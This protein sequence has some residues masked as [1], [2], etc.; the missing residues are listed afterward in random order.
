MNLGFSH[1]EHPLARAGRDDLRRAAARF[2]I[3]RF[4]DSPRR[5]HCFFEWIYFANVAST[6]DDRSVYLARKALGEELA[7]LEDVPIDEDTIVV[8]VPD[9]SKCAA[10]AMAYRARR[11][12]RRRADSQSLHG[13]HVH[14]RQRQP[15]W[16]RPQSK[17]TPLREV[18]EGKRVLLVEDSIVRS[19]TMRVLISRIREVGQGP[20]D[21]RPRGLPA[22]HRALLLRHRHVDDRRAVR[23]AV[24]AAKTGRSKKSTRRWPASSAPIRSATCRSNR[25]PGPSAG[26]PSELCRACITGEYPTPHGQ[27]LYQ[28]ALANVESGTRDALQRLP[29]AADLRNATA[30]ISKLELSCAW[31]PHE[32]RI[33]PRRPTF[34]RSFWVWCRVAALSFGGPAGQIA[35]MH[36]ILVEEKRWVSENRFLHALNYCM[37]LPGPEAQQLATYI[38]WLLH[39]TA[40][41]LM[42]GLLFVLPG[43]V[44]ILLLSILYANV[45]RSDGRRRHFLRPEAGRGR[46]R[47]RSGRC[48]SASGRSR[49]A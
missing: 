1:R 37:L 22:D 14:R 5:A 2:S 12:Q 33:A 13:P 8:P 20:R 18:L 39:R 30:R 28:I 10:D 44:S 15:R 21:S 36:R 35:V 6:M 38:G 4:A 27:Q 9:T 26:R 32:S 31:T 40:G 7:R 34:P 41:G 17:Y 43:F 45:P 49:T 23:A 46:R 16:Q 11:A 24:H 3:E 48:G 19:T 25:S 47:R 29:P 42:A